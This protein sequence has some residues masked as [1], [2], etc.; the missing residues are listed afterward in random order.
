M[1]NSTLILYISALLYAV[2]Y[3]SLRAVEQ[4]RNEERTIIEIQRKI[5][6]V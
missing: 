1:K 3:N 2:I 6:I 4:L 5:Y